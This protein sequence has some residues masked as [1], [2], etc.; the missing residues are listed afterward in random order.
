MSFLN[1]L[2]RLEDALTERGLDEQTIRV[3]KIDLKE[4]LFH[5]KRLDNEAR[6]RY[7]KEQNES[8]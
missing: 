5:Y 3:R 2:Q 4:L 8:N 1:V 6:T 7:E